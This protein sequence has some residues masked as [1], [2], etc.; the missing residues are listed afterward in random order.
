[1]LIVIAPDCANTCGLRIE[2]PIT[3]VMSGFVAAS[4]SDTFESFIQGT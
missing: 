3:I 4:I 1:M 2:H